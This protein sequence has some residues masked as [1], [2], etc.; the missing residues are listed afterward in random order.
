MAE[1]V[2]PPPAFDPAGR[3]AQEERLRATALAQPAIGALSMGMLVLLRDAGLEPQFAAGHSFGELT[4]LWAAGAMDDEDFLRLARERGAAMSVAPGADA[5][6]MLAVAADAAAVS[7]A[8]GVLVANV[9]APDQTVIAGPT[10]AIEA[11]RQ[12]LSDRG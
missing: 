2:F 11:A 1:A 4:A 3:A 6:S 5:G 12:A 9:N 8:G 10:A 7:R